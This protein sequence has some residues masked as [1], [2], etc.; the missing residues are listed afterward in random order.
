MA[1]RVISLLQVT[2]FKARYKMLTC[3][4]LPYFCMLRQHVSLSKDFEKHVACYEQ[5]SENTL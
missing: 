2:Y 1:E 3:H 4:F 5:L